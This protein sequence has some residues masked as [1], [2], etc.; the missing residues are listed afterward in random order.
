MTMNKKEAAE[1]D[2]LRVELS[3]AKALRFSN[4]PQ[5]RQTLP[6]KGYINGWDFNL[7]RRCAFK[8]WTE[9]HGNGEGHRI[10]DGSWANRPHSISQG[11]RPLY[12]SKRDALV[13]MRIATEKECAK[14]LAAIDRM[15][16][17]ALA[18]APEA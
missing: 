4:V 16:D 17:A 14:S 7:Y 11:C 2:A 6:D 9:K 1:M 8:A 13:A 18:D 15:I 10:D 5:P 3:E 12:L